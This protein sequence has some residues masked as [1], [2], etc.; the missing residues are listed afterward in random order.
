MPLSTNTPNQ[1]YRSS[2]PYSPTRSN[3]APT[4][5][6]PSTS[7]GEAI[8][9]I[10]DFLAAALREKKG[11][12]PRS[13]STTPRRA[14]TGLR[15]QAYQATLDEWLPSSDEERRSARKTSGRPPRTRRASDLAVMKSSPASSLGSRD[16]SSALDKLNK[17]NWDLKHRVAL[18]QD[19]VKKLNE[20]LEQA[21]DDLAV[22]SELRQRN[23]ELNEAVDILSKRIASSE[24][25][26]KELTEI[27]DDLVKE[28]ELRDSGIKERQLAIE[29]AAGIIQGL[30]IRVETLQQTQTNQY[31]QPFPR[32]DSDYFSGD[33]FPPNRAVTPKPQQTLVSAPDSDYFSAD[34]SPN[35]TP[36]TPRKMQLPI[37]PKEKNVQ[38]ERA[39][40]TGASFN[41]EV[42]LRTAASRDSLFST[43][44]ETPNLPAPQRQY[45][46][47]LRRKSPAPGLQTIQQKTIPE[48]IMEAARS[49]SPW[50]SSSRPLRSLY[51]QGEFNRQIHSRSPISRPDSQTSVTVV[52]E[53]TDDIFSSTVRSQS[54]ATTLSDASVITPQSNLSPQINVVVPP[55][56]SPL[57]Y[58]SW[59]RKYPEWPP[60]ASLTN[61]D[62]LFHGEEY[63]E[64]LQRSPPKDHRHLR[65]AS[66]TP[67][68]GNRPTRPPPLQRFGTAATPPSSRPAGLDRRRT[69]R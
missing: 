54:P 59:P 29:E 6:R 27:N 68:S 22:A 2:L 15:S 30:E 10:S 67:G 17:E 52:S 12:L 55:N 62:V 35:L 63:D 60:S 9:P 14:R 69:L 28:L 45:S 33:A 51:E 57:N 11:V 7:S 56:P 18:Q 20:E 32:K 37:I 66:A 44:L 64:M 38:L 16:A 50:S 65:T 36:K 42:G 46:R 49:A 4:S 24:E 48:R 5:K 23:E 61:R 58:S 21:L 43:F 41:K 19:R 39:K 13:Q 34:T 25:E 53:S 3:T 8:E 31:L 26:M 1:A 40:Q 47:I